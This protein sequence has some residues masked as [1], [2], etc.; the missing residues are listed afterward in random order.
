MDI[1]GLLHSIGM[2]ADI[3]LDDE[4]TQSSLASVAQT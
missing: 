3:R 4:L 2:K 1:A